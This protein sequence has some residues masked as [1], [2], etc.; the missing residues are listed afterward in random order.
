MITLSAFAD[1]VG[2]EPEVQIST[3]AANGV[4]H[5][6]F[7]GLHGTP[8]LELSDVQVNEFRTMLD[9]AGFNLSAIGS[10]IGKIKVT[11]PFEP[12][13]DQFKRCIELCQMMR[14]PNIRLFSYYYPEGEDPANCRNQVLDRMNA[15]AELAIKA[16]V[17]MRH[18]NESGIYGDTGARCLDLLEN[19]PSEAMEGC[20]DFAN[21][22]HVGEKPAEIWPMLKS[23][24]KQF[25]IKDYLAAESKVVPAGEGDGQVENILRDAVADGFEG[26]ATLEPHLQVAG[27]MRGFTGPDLFRVATDA[28]KKILD[29]IGVE[30]N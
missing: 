6:E 22:V 13:L 24:N 1:E 28:I 27:K 4:K 5:I 30:Y 12:H 29:S 19:V 20:F 11:D 2:P 14:T 18:E 8:V 10:P 9:D 23:T 15:K 25:H 7:R 21:Y 17:V 26:F 3:L 16:G